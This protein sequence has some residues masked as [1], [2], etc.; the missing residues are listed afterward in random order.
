[1]QTLIDNFANSI[2]P[3]ALIV[4]S[5]YVLGRIK[6]L[7]PKQI[8]HIAF[9]IMVPTFIF[10]EVYRADIP[11]DG[12]L[13][14]VGLALALMAILGILCWWLTGAMRLGFNKRAA[15]TISI[16]FMN[17][18][19]LGLY[20]NE[21]AFGQAA[22]A[23]AG[24]FFVTVA[25]IMVV[26]GVYVAEI[27]KLSMKMALLQVI[28]LPLIYAIGVAIVLKALQV[29][30][31]HVIMQPIDLTASGAIPIML[32]LLGVQIAETGLPSEWR[33]VGLVS[34]LRLIISPL[35]ALLL[36]SL[37]NLEILPM[38]VAVLQ[39]AMPVAVLNGVI[40]TEY[41]LEPDLVSSTILVST[42]ISPITLSLVLTALISA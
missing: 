8:S 1:M 39:A 38:K 26:L 2:L 9:Y 40:A 28:K 31:P 13:R 4:L 33:L 23:W 42:L 15:L 18:G 24:I 35:I 36:A 11:V 32:I 6:A 34:G 20:V 19:N 10:R 17:C 30:V 29:E 27:G 21:N 7:D 37:F 25:V 14:M 16:A 12:S 5:G 3:V 41:D 22:L